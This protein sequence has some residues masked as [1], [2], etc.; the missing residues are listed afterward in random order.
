MW[1]Y[2]CVQCSPISAKG[3]QTSPVC[4]SDNSSKCIKMGMNMEYWWNDTYNGT[5]KYSQ[6]R[7]SQGQFVCCSWPGIESRTPRWDASDWPPGSWHCWGMKFFRITRV[8]N[9]AVLTSQE[10]HCSSIMTTSRSVVF[11]EMLVCCENHTEHISTLC[12]QSAKFVN[13]CGTYSYHRVLLGKL[14]AKRESA[15]Y[16]I[17]KIT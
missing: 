4:P 15:S 9:S 12:G 16:S 17:H 1:K 10:T 14:I 2:F 7:L 11:R 3:S 13:R 8:R 5:L 6:K